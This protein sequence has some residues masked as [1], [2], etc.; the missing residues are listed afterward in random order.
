MISER[1]NFPYCNANVGKIYELR[2]ICDRKRAF[3]PLRAVRYP[4]PG[5]MNRLFNCSMVLKPD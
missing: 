3:D 5:Q 4:S 2:E 1:N